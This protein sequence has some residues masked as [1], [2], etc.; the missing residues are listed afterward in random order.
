MDK[1]SARVRR[2]HVAESSIIAPG[3]TAD[4]STPLTKCRNKVEIIEE[5]DD[6]VAVE[7][8]RHFLIAET[9]LGADGNTHRLRR[10]TGK[11]IH[12]QFFRMQNPF[13]F[14][15]GAFEGI[16]VLIEKM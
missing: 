15:G 10:I 6:S 16:D 3:Q 7:I 13:A 11:R 4:F 14:G 9:T 12:R 1:D 8:G 2:A 5:I